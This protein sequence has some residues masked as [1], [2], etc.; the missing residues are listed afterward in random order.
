MPDEKKTTKIRSRDVQGLKYFKVLG[1][2]LERLREV[3]TERD[4]A[5]QRTLHM[6]LYCALLLL[7]LF[8]P[9]IDSLR[10]VQQASGFKKLQNKFGISQTSL[11]SLSETVRIFDPEC[12]KEIAKE[13][14]DQLPRVQHQRISQGDQTAMLHRLSSL[15]RNITAVDGSIVHVLTQ[16]AKL[17]WIKIGDG[18]PTCGYRL[19]TPFEILKGVPHRIDATSANP[20]GPAGERAVLER[21]LEPD[22]LYVMD[23]GY[24]KCS[25]WNAI[26]A[27]QSGYL[28]RVRDKIQ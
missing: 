19:H 18:S 28:C 25:L 15:G 13:L 24:E 2:F 9:I 14:G 12:L 21:T 10:G 11:G 4:R 1:G 20:K 8:S 3:G 23:R 7:W 27:K 16:I 5:N 17:A 22:R 6:D 26:V